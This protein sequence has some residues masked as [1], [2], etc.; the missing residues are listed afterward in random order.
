MAAAVAAFFKGSRTAED[1]SLPRL[2]VALED[3]KGGRLAV[4]AKDREELSVFTRRFL[5]AVNAMRYPR[6]APWYRMSPEDRSEITF[7]RW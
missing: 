1:A 7:V 6:Y 4:S 5:D 2:S 3:G